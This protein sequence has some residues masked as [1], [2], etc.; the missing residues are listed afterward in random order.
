[1]AKAIASRIARD[2]YRVVCPKCAKKHVMSQVL[3]NTCVLNGD[4]CDS[5]RIID[6]Q[7]PCLYPDFVCLNPSCDFEGTVFFGQNK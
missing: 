4:M 3:H 5:F 2:R 1:M 6:G 7:D